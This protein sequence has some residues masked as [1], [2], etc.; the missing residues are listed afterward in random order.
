MLSELAALV[1]GSEARA[2]LSLFAAAASAGVAD[3]KFRA[4]K[5]GAVA[6]FQSE[7]VRSTLLVNRV[8]GL[9]TQTPATGAEVEAL[10]GWYAAHELPFGV[11]FSPAAQPDSLPEL[12]RA[13]KL[14]KTFSTQVLYR[15][16]SP[17]PPHY[18]PW[19]RMTGLRV[20]AV[21]PESAA[22]VARLCCEN[23]Q[24]PAQVGELLA[25]GAVAPGWRRWL[26]LD[27]EH[28]VGASLSYVEDGIGWLGWTNVSASHR[29]RW[30]H[31]GIVARQVQDCHDAGC[32]WIT[33]ETA[34]STREKPDA[35][36]V[37][38]RRFGFEDAY[39]RPTYVHVPRR[40][41]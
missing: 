29:G 18:E 41:S 10:V 40:S 20:E 9:G 31:A 3:T 30:V 13:H 27:G 7:V 37:N 39:C 5:S 4:R 14:R 38:L 1:E 19:A 12:L 11:E 32:R 36:Y 2:Y 21:G 22:T 35:A 16:G 26:A 25:A 28:A 15:D 6:M 33:T 17:P 23:F 34:V 8:L 24:M